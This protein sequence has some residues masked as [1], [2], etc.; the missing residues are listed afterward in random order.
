MREDHR[1]QDLK[2]NIEPAPIDAGDGVDLTLIRQALR[3]TPDERLDLLMGWAQGLEE[4]ADAA[5]ASQHQSGR[6]MLDAA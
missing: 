3:M 2:I 4:L 6:G 5:K 1:P